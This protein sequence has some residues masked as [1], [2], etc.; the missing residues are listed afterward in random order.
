MTFKGFLMGVLIGGIVGGAAGILLAPMEGNETR[1]KIAEVGGNARDKVTGIAT[2][3]AGK[4]QHAAECV[5]QA[6]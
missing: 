6:I 5:R 3:V 4:V 1:R 2:G